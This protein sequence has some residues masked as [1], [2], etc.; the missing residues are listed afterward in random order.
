MVTSV[1]VGVAGEDV[2]EKSLSLDTMQTLSQQ[3]EAIL[4][5]HQALWDLVEAMLR[6]DDNLL[7][8]T[9]AKVVIATMTEQLAKLMKDL[10]VL[11]E[12]M[13]SATPQDNTL[14]IEILPSRLA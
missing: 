5:R 6:E 1:D 7:T 3:V 4:Y 8:K 12:L 14:A 2:V 10:I 11:C 13:S 9:E